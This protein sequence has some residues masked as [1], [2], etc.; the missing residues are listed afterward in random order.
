M[1]LGIKQLILVAYDVLEEKHEIMNL[2]ENSNKNLLQSLIKSFN[3]S[4][5]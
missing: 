2:I 4:L 1:V 3:K 5:F